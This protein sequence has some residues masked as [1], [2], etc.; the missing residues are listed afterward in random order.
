MHFGS[1][2]ARID[3]GKRV[4]EEVGVGSTITKIIGSSFLYKGRYKF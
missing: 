1:L 2:H 4:M 3:E